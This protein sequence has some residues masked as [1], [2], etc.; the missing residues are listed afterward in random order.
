MAL[1]IHAQPPARKLKNSVGQH[2]GMKVFAAQLSAG[3]DQNGAA[4]RVGKADGVARQ[5]FW[6]DG[7]RQVDAAGSLRRQGS[8][9]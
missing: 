4:A 5:F 6:R 1:Y 2:Q 8:Y 3:P 7:Q 9:G